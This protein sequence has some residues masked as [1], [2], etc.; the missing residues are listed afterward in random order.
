MPA[1]APDALFDLAVNRAHAALRGLRPGDPAHA[2]AEWHARTRFAR[3][4]PLEAVRVALSQK[5]D[6]PGE[7]HWAGGPQGGWVAGKAP[8]P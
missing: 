4:V 8:F 2:L 3:R 5:P 7:W 6:A 1:A